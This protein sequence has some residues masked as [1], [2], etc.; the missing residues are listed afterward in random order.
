MAATKVRRRASRTARLIAGPAA[1]LL[2]Y[3]NAAATESQSRFALSATA[4]LSHEAAAQSNGRLQLKAFLSPVRSSPTLQ[5]TG[6]FAL[7]GTLGA[8]SLVC[9][10][11]TIFRDSLD[12]TGL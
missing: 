9:Y 5:S 12:G 3:G 8:S 10:N 6:R 2:A 7:V 1:L 11:D 4:T